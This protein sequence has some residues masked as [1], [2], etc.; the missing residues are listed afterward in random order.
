MAQSPALRAVRALALT[1]SFH[2]PA[3]ADMAGWEPLSRAS[4]FVV[5]AGAA[6]SRGG[7]VAHHVV[8]SGHVARPFRF[9]HYY[10]PAQFPWM[11]LLSDEHIR[12]AVAAA[13]ADTTD[14][15]GGAGCAA[16]LRERLFV[17]P[18]L[19]VA[20]GHVADEP[21]FLASLHAAGLALQPVELLPEPVD[22]GAALRFEGHVLHG[23]GGDV[24]L[25]PHAVPGWLL[26]RSGVQTFAATS[27]LVL[28]MGMCG[29]PVLRASDGGCAGVIEGV[30]PS[31]P[32]APPGGGEPPAPESPRAKA[33]R[34]LAGAAV[35]IDATELRAFLRAVER[36]LS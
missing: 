10:A 9:P 11:S 33:A 27:P 28:E 18:T 24:R 7:G 1:S 6:A 8:M 25:V 2:H 16:E 20:V 5:A 17:H 31:P 15:G 36:Q 30:V 19:D 3:I 34:L 14:G 23:G 21:A 32:A 22:E 13:A 35:M 4:A 26:A 29:G 12:C